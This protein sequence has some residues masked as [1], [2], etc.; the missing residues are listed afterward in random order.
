LGPLPL[1]PSLFY[2]SQAFYFLFQI[3]NLNIS[4]ISRRAQFFFA[5]FFCS[6]LKEDFKFQIKTQKKI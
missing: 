2:F 3:L 1:P 5:L 6:S 4:N